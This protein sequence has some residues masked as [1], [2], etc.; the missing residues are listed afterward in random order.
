MNNHVFSRK[1]KK[2]AEALPIEQNRDPVL[3]SALAT[4]QDDARSQQPLGREALD[5][6]VAWSVVGLFVTF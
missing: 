5:V 3:K 1:K 2:K 4:A 6:A